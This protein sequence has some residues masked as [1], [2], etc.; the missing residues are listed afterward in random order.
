MLKPFLSDFLIYCKS[1]NLAPN[2]IKEILRYI[3]RFDDDLHEQHLSE[4]SHMTYKHVA[5]FVSQDDPS[6]T[7]V[8]ARIRA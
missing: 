3:R 7:T 2:S 5:K 6:L 4:L 8:K 1:L